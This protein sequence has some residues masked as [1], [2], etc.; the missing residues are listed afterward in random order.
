MLN[1]RELIRRSVK[2]NQTKK[3]K[4]EFDHENLKK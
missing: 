3:K 4:D 1:F 2:P